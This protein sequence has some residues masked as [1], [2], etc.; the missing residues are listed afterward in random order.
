MGRSQRHKVMEQAITSNEELFASGV[1]VIPAATTYEMGI[2]RDAGVPDALPTGRGAEVTPFAG[3]TAEN[4]PLVMGAS[5]GPLGGSLVQGPGSEG[6]THPAPPTEGGGGEPEPEPNPAPVITSLDPDSIPVNTAVTVTIHGENF[7]QSSKVL[8]NEAEVL[9]DFI[10]E[11]QLTT[12]LPGF[13]QGG[14]L[15]I[16]V[17]NEDDQ[18]IS[19]SLDFTVTE[20]TPL[21]RRDVEK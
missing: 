14:V 8:A 5:G 21:T 19:N 16:Y 17:L 6:G 3:L 1:G 13:M 4:S 11:T 12:S 20:T 2:P 9:S 7:N 10:S 15:T 18:Q